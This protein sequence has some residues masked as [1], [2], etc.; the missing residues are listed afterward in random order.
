MAPNFAYELCLKKTSRADLQ[1]LSLET[2]RVAVN[3]AE[4]TRVHTME[5][6]SDRFAPIGFRAEAFQPAWGLAETTVFVAARGTGRGLRSISISSRELEHGR[7]VPAEGSG[8]DVQRFA[9]HG[10]PWL[11]QEV[12]LVDPE[13]LRC[14]APG[15]VG[16]IWLRGPSVALGYWKRPD[17]TA[18]T[19]GARLADSGEGPFLRTGDLA[20]IEDSEL[21]SAAGSGT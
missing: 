8:R 15:Q 19:Y 16:E 5:A 3:A 11:D 21:Y 7:V 13:T 4:P 2:W 17:A 10:H 9:A 20:F 18:A 1:G 12:V 6:F 14:S